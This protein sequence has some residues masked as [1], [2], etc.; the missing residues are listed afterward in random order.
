[1]SR[2]YQWIKFSD[3]VEAYEGNFAVAVK[4]QGIYEVFADKK[5]IVVSDDGELTGSPMNAFAGS[6]KTSTEAEKLV[7][8]IDRCYV[9]KGV[10]IIKVESTFKPQS[11][12]IETMSIYS[13]K[14]GKKDSGFIIA[15]KHD[16]V[17]LAHEMGHAKAGHL[18]NK[19]VAGYDAEVEANIE[20]IKILRNKNKYNEEAK[21]H[22]VLGL[23][24]YDSLP[25]AR[26][27]ARNAMHNAEIKAVG[28]QSI[29][30]KKRKPLS[31]PR[32]GKIR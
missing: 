1:M 19:D 13:K 23:S 28:Y 20:A 2:L 30:G 4:L 17:G 31:K 15:D 16:T 24:T 7:K 10:D 21:E 14:Y 3:E 11:Y 12:P 25:F 22:L 9:T 5:G 27:R 26:I 18:N 8:K 29:V 6:Y 32:A